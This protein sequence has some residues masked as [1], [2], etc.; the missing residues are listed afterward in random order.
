MSLQAVAGRLAVVAAVDSMPT[1]QLP[2]PAAA[3]PVLLHA[4]PVL[5]VEAQAQPVMLAHLHLVQELT[6]LPAEAVEV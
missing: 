4:V 6:V 2:P 1:V 5:V 3:V